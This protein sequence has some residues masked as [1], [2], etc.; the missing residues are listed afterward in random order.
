MHKH[1]TETATFGASR[2]FAGMAELAATQ[3]AARLAS[4]RQTAILAASV[5]AAVFAVAFI[6][7]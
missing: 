3:R 6:A 7:F 5:F 2:A 4:I 1:M